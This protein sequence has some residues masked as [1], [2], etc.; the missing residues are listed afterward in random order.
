MRKA[1]IVR[2]KFRTNDIP[3]P[4][5]VNWKIDFAGKLRMDKG[6]IYALYERQRLPEYL[7]TANDKDFIF[8]GIFG[9][10]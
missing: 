9:N 8:S 2:D 3:L 10:S 5:I 7:S 4:W 6:H 1:W